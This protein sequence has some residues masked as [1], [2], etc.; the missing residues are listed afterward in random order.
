MEWRC[1]WCGKPHASD[2]PPC[3]NCGHGS[4][5]RAV[6]QVPG[7]E[8]GA[9]ET[10]VW[11]CESCGRAH[12]KHNPPCSR[13][14]HPTL[15]Q[16]RRGPADYADVGAPSYRDLVTPKYLAG[17]VAALGL[18]V[19]FVLGVTGVVHVPGLTQG[20]VPEV[21]GVPGEA[22]EAGGIDLGGVESSL[23][24]AVNDRR[25][26]AGFP[27]LARD[28]HLEAV[29]T[30]YTRRLVKAEHADGTVPGD[31]E[32]RELLG[33]SCAGGRPVLVP[34]HVT[35]ADSVPEQP[36]VDAAA[37]ALASRFPT[38]GARSANPEK[39]LQGLAVHVGPDGST[40]LTQVL[41]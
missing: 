40:Y 4:F 1:E 2:D 41:C 22:S 14:G 3:D 15:E 19:V 37:Q 17:L 26:A 21:T 5:E 39:R 34:R 38:D 7:G 27:T 36:S 18:A 30:Y 33:E 23:Y 24:E 8:A 20:G 11:V 32:L 9:G 13:C 16:Q 10:T 28:D 31:D 6:V 29:A 35:G 25:E 12:P